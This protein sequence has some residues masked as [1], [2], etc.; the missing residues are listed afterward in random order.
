MTAKR[1]EGHWL[2]DEVEINSREV[3]E[4]VPSTRQLAQVTHAATAF[5]TLIKRAT[6]RASRHFARRS[7]S[8][9]VSPRPIC[10]K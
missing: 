5:S 9:A 1:I 10:R 3:K 7:F 8:T 2:V 6:S 4:A